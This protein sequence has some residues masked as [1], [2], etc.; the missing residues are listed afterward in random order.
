[1]SDMD[2]MEI[3][4]ML[5][6]AGLMSEGTDRRKMSEY[7]KGAQDAIGMMAFYA[8]RIP[9]SGKLEKV[10]ISAS[11]WNRLTMRFNCL[12]IEDTFQKMR[13]EKNDQ[14]K[15]GRMGIYAGEST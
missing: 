15:A 2:L 13:G 6:K 10:E 12:N 7:Y 14:S 4:E 8:K 9:D 11:M 1:M 3:S 5:E